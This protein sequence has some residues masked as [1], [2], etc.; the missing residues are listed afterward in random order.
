M[1][2][3]AGRRLEVIHPVELVKMFVF[4]RS[5]ENLRQLDMRI[6]VDDVGALM[7]RLNERGVI[8]CGTTALSFYDMYCSTRE[9]NFYCSK[10]QLEE[11]KAILKEYPRGDLVVKAYQP[12]FLLQQDINHT[13]RMKVTGEVRT[14]I[15]LACEHR[16]NEAQN[17][18]QKI[19]VT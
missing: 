13:Q 6:R 12:D 7:H 3:K 14:L 19:W 9:L 11:I 4:S 2:E 16:L 17:L 8:F 18:M 10:E 5:M 1:I 15:D